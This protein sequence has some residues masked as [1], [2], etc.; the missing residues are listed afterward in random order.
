MPKTGQSRARRLEFGS[1]PLPH[2]TQ[3]RESIADNTLTF[4]VDPCA[5]DPTERICAT[6]YH[7]PLRHMAAP[8]GQLD[9]AADVS[10]GEMPPTN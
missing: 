4:V 8:P 1:I 2:T 10:A 5:H 9:T 7:R 3:A 6:V